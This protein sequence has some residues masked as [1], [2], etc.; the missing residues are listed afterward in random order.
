MT[1]APGL[2]RLLHESH[3]QRHQVRSFHSKNSTRISLPLLNCLVCFPIANPRKTSSQDC[4]GFVLKYTSKFAIPLICQVQSRTIMF[5]PIRGLTRARL[6][7]WRMA[8]AV[9]RHALNFRA[10]R[11]HNRVS[12]GLQ[13][14]HA[15]YPPEVL[16]ILKELW[17][18][19]SQKLISWEK[20]SVALAVLGGAGLGVF[21]YT[22]QQD[23]LFTKRKQFNFTSTET[24]ARWMMK[25]DA[26]T[27]MTY[28]SLGTLNRF[29]PD[30]Q[31]PED[32]PSYIAVFRIFKRILEAGH[33]NP[34]DRLWVLGIIALNG[35][36]EASQSLGAIM[37][38]QPP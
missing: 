14:N 26:E 8:G 20:F 27:F 5:S 6:G 33:Y 21:F 2:D 16:P 11:Y 36:S 3:Q 28:L 24:A 32:H 19:V 13:P 38:I 30:T 1:A 7:P 9:P 23:V 34:E 18:L 22:H 29:V 10:M 4:P 15:L 31:L 12:P 37:L 25:N 35:E 17:V